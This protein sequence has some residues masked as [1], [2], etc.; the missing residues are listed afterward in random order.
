MSCHGVVVGASLDEER[1]ETGLGV[2]YQTKNHAAAGVGAHG[3]HMETWRGRRVRVCGVQ[4][5]ACACVVVSHETV[6]TRETCV[7]ATRAVEI[8]ENNLRR[9]GI[10]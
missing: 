6:Q 1:M 2:G 5:R 8:L 10:Q 9:S 7:R 3:G 4:A